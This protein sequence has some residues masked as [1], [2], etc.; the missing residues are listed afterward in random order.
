MPVTAASAS[1]RA[2]HERTCSPSRCD[3]R[4]LRLAALAICLCGAGCR[5]PEPK[6]D[7]VQHRYSYACPLIAKPVTVDGTLD[8]EAWQGAEVIREFSVPVTHE[9]PR[10]E[11]EARIMYD[12]RHLYVAFEAEDQD[13]L[14]VHSVRDTDTYR[15]DVLEIFFKTGPDEETLYNFEINPL[16]TLR[17]ETHTP[18]ERF[19]TGWNCEGIQVAVKIIGTLNNWQDQDQHWQLEVAIPFASLPSLGGKAP[20]AGDS[21]RFHVS[22]IERSVRSPKGRE[23]TS[24]APLTV[25]NFHSSKD[26]LPLEFQDARH[27]AGRRRTNEAK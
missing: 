22:R 24:C 17:D 8:E 6:R 12:E 9:A 20:K 19:Q 18:T 2:K 21:W 13:I 1:G 25:F 4:Y 15:D 10:R 3:T 23:A 14:A 5:T 27:H 26:W 16:G 11:T 7:G